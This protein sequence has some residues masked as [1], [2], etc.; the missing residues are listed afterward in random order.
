MSNYDFQYKQY[1]EGLKN[2]SGMKN[3]ELN[4]KFDD[5]IP[6]Y[7]DRYGNNGNK[8]KNS[9]SAL[10]WYINAFILQLVGSIMLFLL[11]FGAKF[12]DNVQLKKVYKFLKEGVNKEVTYT[13]IKQDIEKLDTV[14]VMN[15]LKKSVDW[16]KER[17]ESNPINQ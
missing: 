8:Y 5:Y 10:S 7:S 1:Y 2:K 11:V 3:Q 17:I 9:Q 12:S 13:D 16:V 15:N 4:R 6:R 14:T